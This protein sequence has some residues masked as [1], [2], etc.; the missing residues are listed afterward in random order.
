MKNG[1]ESDT[2]VNSGVS[3]PG[4]SIE[5]ILGA[6]TTL[7]DDTLDQAVLVVEVQT[8]NTPFAFTFKKN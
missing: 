3:F 6:A 7:D 8:N 5:S 1:E 2:E 4:E